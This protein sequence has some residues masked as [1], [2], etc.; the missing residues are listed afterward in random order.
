MS[1]VLC[2]HIIAL[3]LIRV[4]C[5]GQWCDGQVAPSL[6]YLEELIS[7]PDGGCSTLQH[8]LLLK[9]LDWGLEPHALG[10]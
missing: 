1:T 10:R 5:D 9:M 2:S 7:S 6:S 8:A 4:W 3:N